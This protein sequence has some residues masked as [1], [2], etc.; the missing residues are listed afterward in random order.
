TPRSTGRGAAAGRAAGGVLPGVLRGATEDRHAA[1]YSR[2]NSREAQSRSR[3]AAVGRGTLY[4]GSQRKGSPAQ[5]EGGRGDALP[6][7]D[8]VGDSA[9][10]HEL[11]QLVAEP[12]ARVDDRLPA[13]HALR[14]GER[15]EVAAVGNAAAGQRG[16]ERVG[17][18]DEQRAT[19]VVPARAAPSQ[20]L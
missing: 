15:V 12:R 5:R 18:R 19:E 6:G 8:R 10:G 4:P 13:S 2:T 17:R 20:R 1:R 16:D 9:S 7:Y 14:F 3:V 11:A